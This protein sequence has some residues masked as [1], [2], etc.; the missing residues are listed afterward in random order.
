MAGHSKWANIKHRKGAQDAKRGKIFTKLIKEITVSAREGG[1][2][3]E[4]NPRLRLAIQNAK[5]QNMPKDNIERAISKAAGA[6]A[7]EY[8][9]YTYEG[10]A[11]HGIAVFVETATDNQN[12]TVASV[13]SIFSKYGGSLSVSGSVDYMFE[14][15]GVFLINKK[16]DANQDELTLELIDGGAQEV[17]FNEDLIHV[18]CAMEDFGNM[19]AK[20]DELGLDVDNAEL[21]RIPTTT[22]SLTDDQ[23]QSVIKLIDALEDDDDVQKVYHNL[24]ATE[25]QMSVME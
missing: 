21:Q 23:F 19:Q 12:R 9:E 7:V 4:T 11:P 2:D 8:T 25:E 5:A 3:P 15:K 24:E 17:E 6:D 22:L 1:P 14:R 18:T 20:V 13:R 16:E 10:Y